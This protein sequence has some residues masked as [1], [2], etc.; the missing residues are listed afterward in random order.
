MECLWIAYQL[1]QWWNQTLKKKKKEKKNNFTNR[2][3]THRNHYIIIYNDYIKSLYIKIASEFGVFKQTSK[4]NTWTTTLPW[5][6][7]YNE[8]K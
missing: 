2:D 4:Q 7:N 8:D 1:Y 3:Q 6:W 5:I